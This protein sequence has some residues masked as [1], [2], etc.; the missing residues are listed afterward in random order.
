[1]LGQI[2]TV[3]AKPPA[4]CWHTVVPVALVCVA[5]EANLETD[6]KELGNEAWWAGSRQSGVVSQLPPQAA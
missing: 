1:M 5:P 4:R 6:C 2:C 3:Y